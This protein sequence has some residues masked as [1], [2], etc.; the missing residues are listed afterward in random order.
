MI[1]IYCLPLL[2]IIFPA[3]IQQIINILAFSLVV[4]GVLRHQYGKMKIERENRLIFATVI[5]DVLLAIIFVNRWLPSGIV[6]NMASK[7]NLNSTVL[8]I[9]IG[10]V[11]A[12]LS[13]YG[14]YK[15]LYF[16]VNYVIHF[17]EMKLIVWLSNNS[18]SRKGKVYF[19][20]F[21]ALILW[22]SQATLPIYTDIDNHGISMILNQN[23]SSDNYCCFVSPILSYLVKFVNMILPTADGFVLIMELLMTVAMC[24]LA[25]IL[26]SVCKNKLNVILVWLFIVFV[27]YCL[28]IYHA[29]FTIY[30][31]VLCL[32]GC[33]GLFYYIKKQIGAI[34]AITS[35]LTIY[36]AGMFRFNSLLLIIPFFIL[37]CLIRLFVERKGYKKYILRFSLIVLSI[38]LCCGCHKVINSFVSGSDTYTYATHYN[39]ERSKLFDFENYDYEEI[40]SELNKLN[41]SQNDYNSIRASLLADTEVVTPE[42][43]KNITAVSQ[44][45]FS[46]KIYDLHKNLADVLY[47][48]QTDTALS[49]QCIAFIFFILLL[50]ILT[51]C[52][53]IYV[54]ELLLSCLGTII[55]I[56]YFSFLGRIPDRVIQSIF[57]GN[58]FVYISAFLNNEFKWKFRTKRLLG[59]L[60]GI[61][62]AGIAISSVLVVNNSSTVFSSITANKCTTEPIKN[63]D[64]KYIWNTSSYNDYV[65]NV[66]WSINKL[67][68]IEFMK[69]NISD[70][71]WVY[72]QVCYNDYLNSIGLSN[73]MKSLLENNVYYVSDEVRCDMVLT[74]LKE[75]YDKNITV[76]QV[77]SIDDTP[78]WKF[79]KG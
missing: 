24:T 53:Y 56:L 35:L 2:L 48:L 60:Y 22:L 9:C 59:L 62:I 76:E 47:I 68:S 19:S 39:S 71:K 15:L 46:E 49:L 23:Y 4:C 43:M 54:C 40:S 38:L 37:T 78:V 13:F 26:L 50:I 52:S 21:L 17:K 55:I 58:W 34:V 36:M 11:L 25:Y 8:L 31:S 3:S 57:I 42:Y 73:P 65:D 63:S 61:M 72:G 12:I 10:V 16:L 1:F 14:T 33:M 30:T 51:D 5:I 6:S 45:D 79:S 70:G 27:N 20:V 74:F 7:I 69:Q 18:I 66:F 67:P 44:H 32:V 28:N 64:N 75:H 41:I 29:N 77:D